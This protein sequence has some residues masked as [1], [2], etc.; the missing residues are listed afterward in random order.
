MFLLPSFFHPGIL[1]KVQTREPN[2]ILIN[3]NKEKSFPRAGL[4]GAASSAARKNH[5][6]SWI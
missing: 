1:L 6:I 3:L 4:K 5:N 2:P